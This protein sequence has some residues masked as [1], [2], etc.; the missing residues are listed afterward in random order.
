MVIL[1]SQQDFIE[2]R[3]KSNQN[4]NDYTIFT[5]P[6]TYSDNDIIEINHKITS[7]TQA[8]KGTWEV[9]GYFLDGM[10]Q[11]SLHVCMKRGK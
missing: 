11:K 7:V 6:H 4:P 9:V 10:S 3:K 5:A 8:H 1:L 2:L